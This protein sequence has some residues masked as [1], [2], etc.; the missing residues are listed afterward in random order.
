MS[1]TTS[2]LPIHQQPEACKPNCSRDWGGSVSKHSVRGTMLKNQWSNLASFCQH[3]QRC[4]PLSGVTIAFVHDEHVTP[5]GAFCLPSRLLSHHV[6]SR[7][8][9]HTKSN[10]VLSGRIASFQAE[11]L[12][13]V[14]LKSIH[15][16]LR[17]HTHVYNLDNGYWRRVL[18]TN[19]MWWTW[20]WHAH[21]S[22][23]RWSNMGKLRRVTFVASI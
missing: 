21:S 5:S 7:N 10:H 22:Q 20:V 9:A 8:L 13:M 15:T 11:K 18:N 17:T 23:A 3:L 12:S 14:L 19:G 2:D 6:M 1:S 4:I 16:I